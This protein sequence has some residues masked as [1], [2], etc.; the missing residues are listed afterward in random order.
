MLKDILGVNTKNDPKE[1]INSI[2]ITVHFN[3]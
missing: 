2:G 1:Y 3:K